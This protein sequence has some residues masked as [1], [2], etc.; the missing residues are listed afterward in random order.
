MMTTFH[1]NYIPSKI[2]SFTKGA[3]DIIIK[4]CKYLNIS[5]MTYFYND[6]EIKLKLQNLFKK[7]IKIKDYPYH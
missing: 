4:K 6:M 3:P 2:V 5:F 7:I 1:R